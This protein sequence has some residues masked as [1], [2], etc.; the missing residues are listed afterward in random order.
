MTEHEP[1]TPDE[2]V[3]LIYCSYCEQF[4]VAGDVETVNGPID[5]TDSLACPRCHHRLTSDSFV[6]YCDMRVVDY[7]N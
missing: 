2:I 5:D 4:S 6:D 1:D 3:T 7:G